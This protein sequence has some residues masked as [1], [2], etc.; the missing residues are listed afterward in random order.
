[1]IAI[2]NIGVAMFTAY[3]SLTQDQK[4]Q[5]IATTLDKTEK[6]LIDHTVLE[7][8]L[9]KEFVDTPFRKDV[10][11]GHRIRIPVKYDKPSEMGWFGLNDTFSPQ[12]AE[13][14]GWGYVT[15]CQAVKDI[16]LEDLES[17]MNDG[18]EAF[19][20]LVSEKL[21]S[22]EQVVKEGLNDA[23]WADGTG[24][25]GK[26]P[27]GVTGLISNT[28]TVGSFM[29]FD[30]STEYWARNWYLDNAIASATI[31]PHSLDN[32]TNNSP[33]SIGAIG[34]ISDGYPTI[35]D[36]LQLMWRSI[37]ANEDPTNIIH[38]TDLQTELWYQKIPLRM[39]G[40]DIG[41]F[42][43]DLNMGVKNVSF[44]GAKVISDTVDRG[45][46]TG[47]W[48]MINKRYYR[49]YVDKPRFM[50]WVGP[51]SP[52]NALRS[53]YYLVVRLAWACLFPR[54]MG[55]YTGIADWTA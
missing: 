20:D 41:V 39:R 19:I 46:P 50:K 53:A 25:G 5:I 35:I 54:R 43:G 28:P 51:R 29:N 44:M 40:A 10:T 48:R 8:R 18:P 23:A 27:V 33:S 2:L 26:A 11:G 15:L 13:M 45:A 12:P 42:E 52:Y 55:I 1:M 7:N 6:E 49:L 32:P 34:D 14:H 21:N 38:L 16:A 37:Y 17:W 31:G 9:Y 3:G 4:D 47:E 24:A 30:L 36:Y 22:V